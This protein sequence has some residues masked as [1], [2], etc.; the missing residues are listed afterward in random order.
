MTNSRTRTVSTAERASRIT[1]CAT[2]DLEVH[3]EAAR[4]G[5]S[6]DSTLAVT[7]AADGR[8]ARGAMLVLADQALANGVFA[9][10]NAKQAMMTLDLRVDWLALPPHG[11]TIEAVVERVIRHGTIVAVYGVL[12]AQGGAPRVVVATSCARFLTGSFPGGGDIMADLPN[13]DAQ[14]SAAADFATLLA[15]QTDNE[16]AVLPPNP[17][18]V[19]SPMLPA[20]HG[21]F[22]AAALEA[23]SSA[24]VPPGP[25]WAA[26]NIEVRYI[27]PARATAPLYIV[28]KLLR[29]SRRTL[30]I[31]AQALQGDERKLV[32]TAKLMFFHSGTPEAAVEVVNLMAAI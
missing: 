6:I 27:R 31:E 11:A 4:A 29:A 25:G 14:P 26:V 1:G 24:L 28:P 22:I 18:L 30:I 15:L 19:G 20:V 23:A 8:M 10:F 32:A 17:A 9:A 2:L 3:E 21:G 5:A 13:H 12:L 7:Q 16:V